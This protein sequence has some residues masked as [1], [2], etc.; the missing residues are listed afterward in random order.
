L[1]VPSAGRIQERQ[2]EGE[3]LKE[4]PLPRNAA[5]VCRRHVDVDRLAELQ[6]VDHFQARSEA[7]G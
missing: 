6:R 2:A 5:P 1:V 3:T 4:Q 7:A